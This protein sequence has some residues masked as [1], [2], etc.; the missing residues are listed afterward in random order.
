MLKRLM[1]G[2]AVAIVTAPTMYAGAYPFS[3]PQGINWEKISAA[4]AAARR[5]AGVGIDDVVVAHAV[6]EE[7][8]LVIA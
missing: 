5:F 4:A 2:L 7:E 6:L 8:P 1:L 3:A